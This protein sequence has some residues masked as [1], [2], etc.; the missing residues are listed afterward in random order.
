MENRPSGHVVLCNTM[1]PSV[2]ITRAERQRRHSITVGRLKVVKT[3]LNGIYLPMLLTDWL[4]VEMALLL[5][6]L[7]KISL[8]K[9]GF[10]TRL[11]KNRLSGCCPWSPTYQFVQILGAGRA[12]Q[13]RWF[14]VVFVYL[15][16]GTFCGTENSTH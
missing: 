3:S 9:S 6:G 13:S 8:T 10:T 7:T 11:L 2:V 1:Q 5:I 15:L 14:C 16:P 12:R 4:L